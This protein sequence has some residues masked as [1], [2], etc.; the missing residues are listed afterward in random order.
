MLILSIAIA[1]FA[2]IETLNILTLYFAPGTRIGNG[3]GVFDAYEKSRSDPE[4]HSFVGYLVDWVAGTKLIFVALLAVI[5]ATGS[6]TTRLLAVA[7]LIPSVLTYFWRLGPSI[8]KMDRAGWIT[9]TGY[10]KT[11]TIM[12]A[13]FVAGFAAAVGVYLV[14]GGGV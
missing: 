13:A 10:S 1:V 6:E 11:L 8:R 4:V 5:L 3:V 12:I 9:P 7:V 14:F 2:V